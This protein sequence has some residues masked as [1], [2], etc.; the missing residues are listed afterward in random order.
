MALY[1][2]G[3]MH[4]SLGV[5][6]PMDIFGP[7]WEGYTEKLRENLSVLR[8]EDTLVM[9]GDFSWGISLAE[10]LPDFK[11]LDA[12]PGRKLL[13]KGNHDLW[14]ETA[15]K[16]GRFFRENGITT[17][18]FLHNNCHLYGNA[19]LCGTRGWS[20]DDSA[21][22]DAK[23]LAREAGRLKISLEAAKK[24]GA[25][26]IYCFMHYPPVYG[27]EVLAEL[28]GLMTAYGVTACYYGHLHGHSHRLAFEGELD[29][30]VYRLVAGDY[31]K[32]KPVLINV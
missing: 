4:L 10:A 5:D 22:H 30:V 11:F 32:F 9:C 16:M 27:G 19:A 17:I 21:E 18:D 1:A 23:M 24:S 20:L 3:D 28:C 31:L 12:F 25:E 8:P 15:S 26:R 13:V 14:W 7:N 6:K 2:I 29:G